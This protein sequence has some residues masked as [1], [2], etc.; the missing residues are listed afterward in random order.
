LM[1][2]AGMQI[3]FNIF[4][5]VENFIYSVIASMVLFL[6]SS[7][8]DWLEA[9]VIDRYAWLKTMK[10]TA[11]SWMIKGARAFKMFENIANPEKFKR[12]NAVKSDD[13]HETQHLLLWDVPLISEREKL[14]TDHIESSKDIP[15]LAPM[16][17]K[18][19]KYLSLFFLVY[20]FVNNLGDVQLRLFPKPD[21]GN[22]GELLRIDQQWVM[23]GPDVSPY[24]SFELLIGEIH[25]E[26]MGVVNGSASG[27]DDG[28]QLQQRS[29]R[30]VLNDLLTSNWKKVTV[31]EGEKQYQRP[32]NPTNIN[33]SMRWER[34]LE[35]T[36][37]NGQM[38][39]SVLFWFCKHVKERELV[40]R[41]QDHEKQY[42]RGESVKEER[43]MAQT[44]K[45]AGWCHVSGQIV[46]LW[47]QD[48]NS[49]FP[50]YRNEQVRCGHPVVCPK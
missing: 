7:F 29:R 10:M 12:E 39:D 31:F 11:R 43:F 22:I 42:D 47:K 30:I 46:D 38:K 44:M 18:L 50:Q 21:G 27:A 15:L 19:N 16:P 34:F 4:I 28:E 6:P 25:G 49:S 45:R 35:K 33:P 41:Y 17:T 24:T 40:L 1:V 14:N 20:L 26:S 23:Y 3:G 48:S 36:G 13:M 37:R 5:R 9:Q 2:L 32:W 8:W